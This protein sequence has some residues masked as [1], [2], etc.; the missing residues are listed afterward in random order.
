MI[1]PVAIPTPGRVGFFRRPG[2]GAFVMAV[3]I[4]AFGFYIVYPVI[5]IF[6]H[7]FNVGSLREPFR[8]GLDHWRA[9][10]AQPGIVQSLLNTVLIYF[11]YT[12]IAFPVAV[13]IAWTLARTRIPFS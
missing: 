7:S 1:R 4:I 6:V 12:A 3:L 13:L 5:L 11:A 8:F 10:F 9:A 2:A